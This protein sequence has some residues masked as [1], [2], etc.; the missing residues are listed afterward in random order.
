MAI[1]AKRRDGS[2]MAVHVLPLAKPSA[3][4]FHPQGAVAAVFLAAAALALTTSASL[5]GATYTLKA[6]DGDYSGTNSQGNKLAYYSAD[7]T[8]NGGAISGNGSAWNGSG[9]RSDHHSRISRQRRAVASGYRRQGPRQV[10][11][12]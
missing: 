9:S 2:A 8:G 4:A 11:A 6:G 3:Q 7:S 5:A 1:P 10:I 12:S